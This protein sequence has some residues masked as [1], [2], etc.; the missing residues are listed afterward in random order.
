MRRVRA[1]TFWFGLTSV[2]ALGGQQAAAAPD[3]NSTAIEQVVV[4]ATKRQEDVQSVP[5]AE[6]AY[7]GAALER[8]GVSSFVDV[9][10][11]VPGLQIAP[12][13]N[14]GTTQVLIRGIG[15]SGANPGFE[16]SVG[17]FIDG[18]FIPAAGPIQ[19]QLLDI[20]SIDVLRGPQGTLYGRNT[21]V[22]ALN[23]NTKAP[24]DERTGMLKVAYGNYNARNISGYV[25]GRLADGLDG[26]LTLWD[27]A[28][29]GYQRNIYLR[30]DVNDNNQWGG[31]G[32]LKWRPTDTFTDNFIGY[33]SRISGHCCAPEPV[34]PTGV[35]GIATPGYLAAAAAVGA[36]FVKF[37]SL[38]N[39]VADGDRGLDI[40][41]IY[42]VSNQADWNLAKGFVATSITAYNVY[43]EDN[44]DSVSEGLPQIVSNVSQ[45]RLQKAVSEELRL[46]SPKGNTIDFLAGAYFYHQ[47]TDFT[48]SIH[49]TPMANR[50]TPVGGLLPTDSGDYLFHQTTDSQALFG[51]ATWNVTQHLR[52]IGGLRQSWE[53]KTGFTSTTDNPTA[54]RAFKSGIPPNPGTQLAHDEHKLTWMS[55]VQYDVRDG[56]MAYATAATGWKSG[57]F[58]ARSSTVGTPLTFG[59]EDSTDYE[60][61]VKSEFFDRTLRFNFD[62]YE[63]QEKNIQQAIHNP[64]TGVGFIVG[65]LGNVKNTGFE[66][67]AIWR[68]IA[69][70]TFSATGAFTR[71]HTYD[72]SAGQCPTYPGTVANGTVAGTC[73]FN[74]RRPAFNPSVTYSLGVDW[75]QTIANGLQGFVD[76]NA[77]YQGKQYE[78]PT[79]DPRSLQ[80]P[81][82]LLNAR[83]GIGGE[84]G[85][86]TAALFGRNLT[87]AAYYINTA[88]QPQASFMSA[89]GTSSPNGW[90]GW[91]GPPRTFGAELTYQFW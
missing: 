83:L 79:L 90:V 28:H 61:G 45:K 19:A 4:T 52:V 9:A 20:A 70:L 64:V 26:R 51:Q 87:G 40:A 6:T 46:A 67:D 71:A 48:Q 39:T 13:N 63:L 43:D 56:V 76:L 15:S 29:D 65:N 81:F 35:G 7:S 33:F 89:G 23:I 18:V 55:T 68:P 44:P 57:G 30:A 72:F 77:S 54:S 27:V 36:P 84:N 31:R 32:R 59:P 22:G 8:M 42:G 21:S 91:Y 74:G 88:S 25:G 62:V 5:I 49:L 41:K 66:F 38:D 16:P 14:N 78:D 24:T 12:A 11:F 85:R 10:R 50:L 37:T 53:S 82:V 73:S 58:N 60:V 1:R 80:R 69:P 75:R 86:W 47:T 34:N 17:I 3:P 2:V